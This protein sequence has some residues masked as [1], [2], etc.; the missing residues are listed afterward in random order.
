MGPFGAKGVPMVFHDRVNG[1]EFLPPI[2]YVA[3]SRCEAPT[4]VT[5]ELDRGVLLALSA[6]SRLLIDGATPAQALEE[7]SIIAQSIREREQWI[8]DAT[9]PFNQII[10]R[11][12]WKHRPA[13]ET[14]VRP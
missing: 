11:G 6:V 3:C 7:I 8:M 10:E 14:H 2:Q 12:T 9:W 5:H 13:G 1:A 4:D